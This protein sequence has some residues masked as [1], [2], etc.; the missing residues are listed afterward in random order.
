MSVVV[1]YF[2]S[3]KK[4]LSGSENIQEPRPNETVNYGMVSL[5]D[6]MSVSLFPDRKIAS[7]DYHSCFWR[8]SEDDPFKNGYVSVEGAKAYFAANKIYV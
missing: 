5:G 3:T 7:S 2:Q 1:Y 8:V 4:I 6:I